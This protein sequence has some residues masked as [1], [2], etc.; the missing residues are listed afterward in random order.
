MR[1]FELAAIDA[2]G[3]VVTLFTTDTATEALDKF[4]EAHTGYRR[5]WVVDELGADV[6]IDRLTEMANEEKRRA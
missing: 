6:S 4:K 1:A 2:D 5:A 3:Q